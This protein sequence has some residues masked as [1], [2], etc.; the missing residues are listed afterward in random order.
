MRNKSLPDIMYRVSSISKSF[1]F[2]E[3]VLL[4]ITNIILRAWYGVQQIRKQTITAAVKN[5][6]CLYDVESYVKF[7][8]IE[9]VLLNLYVIMRKLPCIL[10]TVFRLFSIFALLASI[11]G[12]SS[13]FF[14]A[15]EILKGR[16]YLLFLALFAI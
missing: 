5:I 14:K 13:L 10:I 12:P 4:V 9:I 3:P 2:L 15:L 8:S 11:I 6:Y 7:L 1:R 16:K